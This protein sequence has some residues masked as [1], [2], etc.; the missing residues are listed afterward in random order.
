[1]REEIRLWGRREVGVSGALPIPGED[2]PIASNRTLRLGGE[3]LRLIFGPARKRLVAYAPY[4]A[5]A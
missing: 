2:R 1:M 5:P 4:D 3:L